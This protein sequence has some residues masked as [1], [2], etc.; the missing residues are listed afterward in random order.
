MKHSVLQKL[1]QLVKEQRRFLNLQQ[2]KIET[3]KE[4]NASVAN[5]VRRI[6]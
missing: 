6:W 1:Q 2:P 5:I 4:A 3:E